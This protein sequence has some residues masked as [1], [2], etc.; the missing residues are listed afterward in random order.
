MIIDVTQ[1]DIFN[2]KKCSPHSCPLALAIVKQKEDLI[3]N[4]SSMQMSFYTIGG[5]WIADYQLD[6][7][8]QWFVERFDHD[9]F[10]KPFHFE[11]PDEIINR[12]DKAVALH[13]KSQ[14][15]R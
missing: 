6:T 5:N 2:G 7:E 8:L 1:D 9:M 13:K 10:V 4:I 11:I 12:V 15:T 14:E 3:V